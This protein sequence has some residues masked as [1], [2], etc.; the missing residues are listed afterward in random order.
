MTKII[1]LDDNLVLPEYYNIQFAWV[2]RTNLDHKLYRRRS[3]NDTNHG[4]DCVQLFLKN[5]LDCRYTGEVE[6]MYY[7]RGE[8]YS[9]LHKLSKTIKKNRNKPE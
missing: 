8:P 9:D 2:L 4:A 5:P 7:W 1:K 6:T 3:W